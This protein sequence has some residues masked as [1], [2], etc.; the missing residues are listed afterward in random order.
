[1]SKISSI[2]ASFTTCKSLDV[3]GNLSR[4]NG[5][6]IRVNWR[7]LVN[8]MP[9]KD[10]PKS[11]QAAS[12][13]RAKK[14]PT[15]RSAILKNMGR[16]TFV[17]SIAAVSFGAVGNV[18]AN[19]VGASVGE[20]S[21]T[22]IQSENSGSLSLGEEAV[23]GENKFAIDTPETQKSAIYSIFPDFIAI[24]PA[25]GAQYVFVQVNSE[26]GNASTLPKYDDFYL[27]TDGQVY[28]PAQRLG[29]VDIRSFSLQ[30][31]HREGT[32]THDTQFMPEGDFGEGTIGFELPDPI[33][34]HTLKIGLSDRNTETNY[35]WELR[36]E[37][38]KFVN[39]QNGLEY[40]DYY[41]DSEQDRVDAIATIRNNASIQQTA[42]G[43]F[44]LENMELTKSFE[45]PIAPGEERTTKIGISRSHLPRRG[46]TD[47]AINLRLDTGRGLSI[48]GEVEIEEG[49]R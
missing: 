12:E 19:H 22:T 15:D 43:V 33:E 38:I 9:T 2:V 13:N 34:T 6:Q 46:P 45:L 7:L 49:S 42:R 30:K 21:T 3:I 28:S 29:E 14:Q 24:N 10:T 1:M 41:F 35:P 5:V 27:Q 17:S 48:S 18:Q 39:E 20:F 47:G 36:N 37:D 32:Y 31:S 23:I 26:V 44:T 4:V 40:R 16:R 11:E 25:K 8:Q